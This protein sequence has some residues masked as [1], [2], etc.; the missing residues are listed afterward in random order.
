MMN[1]QKTRSSLISI[2]IG[3]VYL[4]FGGL[5]FFPGMSPAEEL[6]INTIDQLSFGILA[7]RISLILLAIWETTIGIFL[8]FNIKNRVVLKLAI[9]HIVC[10]FTPLIFFPDI[11][12]G[13]NTLSLSLLGQYIIKNVVILS[14]LLVLLSE[15]EQKAFK[16][17]KK[18][19]LETSVAR[20]N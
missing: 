13:E 4:W 6:A 15:V 11:V 17:A 12:F 5:K 10:T 18:K 19:K 3:L 16:K 9:L 1:S 8:V 2:S 14:T 20:T 7:P